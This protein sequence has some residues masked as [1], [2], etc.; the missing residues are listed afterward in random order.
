VLLMG[1]AGAVVFAV[2]TA[3]I[4][5]VILAMSFTVDGSNLSITRRILHFPCAIMLFVVSPRC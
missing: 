2:V 5:C 4:G 3:I 1:N